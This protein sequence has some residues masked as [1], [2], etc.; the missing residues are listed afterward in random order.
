MRPLFCALALWIA[1][2][3]DQAAA[4]TFTDPFAYCAA[5][6]TIDRPDRHFRGRPP[7][8]QTAAAF[9]IEA[10]PLNE[11]NLAWRCYN[12]G[13]YACAQLNS[14]I[15]GKADTRR[16]PTQ[17]MKQFCHSNPGSGVIPL[18]VMG[19]EHPPMYDWTCRGAKPTIARQVFTPDPRGYP[20]DLWKKLAR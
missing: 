7:L 16:F 1:G 13:V 4:Q 6:G 8:A 18:A 9:D 3:A 10:G 11:R 17:V 15:C 20:P 19:H 14:P 2:M 5:M 12:G